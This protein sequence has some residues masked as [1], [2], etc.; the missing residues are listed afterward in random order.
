MRSRLGQEVLQ[1][2]ER[3]CPKPKK[4]TKC[5]KP[6]MDIDVFCKHCGTANAEHDAH[7]ALACQEG[8]SKN[9]VKERPDRRNVAELDSRATSSGMGRH[10]GEFPAEIRRRQT[11]KQDDAAVPSADVASLASAP[12]AAIAPTA[13]SSPTSS[14]AP[15]AASVSRAAIETAS[16]MAG[17]AEEDEDKVAHDLSNRKDVEALIEHIIKSSGVKAWQQAFGPDSKHAGLPFSPKNQK[18][19]VSFAMRRID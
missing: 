2:V 8:H 13:A 16:S 14:A 4:C 12:A 11:P 17:S 6:I 9:R 5:K 1:C 15:T 19:M 18:R 7:R 10:V 3:V